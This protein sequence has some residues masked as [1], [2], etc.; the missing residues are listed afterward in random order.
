MKADK[1]GIYILYKT[2]L[3]KESQI[4]RFKS[5]FD[6]NLLENKQQIG[7]K[8]I[9]SEYIYFIKLS[10]KISPKSAEECEF[11]FLI[12]EFIPIFNY[13]FSENELQMG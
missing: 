11:I 12:G 8:P 10:W 9:K 2:I 1:R 13:F 6:E 5:I 3:E 7:R 4:G